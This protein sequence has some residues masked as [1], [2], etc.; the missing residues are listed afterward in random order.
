MKV[1]GKITKILD[2]Q[3]GAKKDGGAWVKLSF[4]IKTDEMYNNLYCFELFGDEKVESFEKFN[5]VGQT[6]EVDF[7]VKCNEWKGK[8]YTSLDAWKVFTATKQI[9]VHDPEVI[10]REDDSDFDF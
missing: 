9:E 3:K 8:Y 5:K 1:T 2:K 6:V 10:E 7:N 4:L